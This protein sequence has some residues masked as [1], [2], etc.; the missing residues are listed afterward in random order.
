M[1]TPKPCECGCGLPAPIASR[2]RRSRGAVKGEPLR[3]VYGHWPVPDPGRRSDLVENAPLREAFL[4]LRE[5]EGLTAAQVGRRLGS[6]P[7]GVT[8]SLGL[9]PQRQGG[10]GAPYRI[11]LRTPLAHALKLCEAMG[12]DPVDVGL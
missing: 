3:Y 1:T 9:R 4:E 12:L 11:A 5:T 8:R 7:D 10:P 6:S 2:T